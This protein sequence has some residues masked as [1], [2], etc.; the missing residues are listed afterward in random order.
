[1]CIRDRQW[2]IND[3]FTPEVDEALV[4]LESADGALPLGQ[5]DWSLTEPGDKTK[6][7]GKCSVTV[8]LQ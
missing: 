4:F 3:R 1:M 8:S 6:Y 2:F 5:R 7:A